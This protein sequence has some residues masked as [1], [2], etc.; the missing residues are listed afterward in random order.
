M[1]DGKPPEAIWQPIEDLPPDAERRGSARHRERAQRWMH[2]FQD[3]NGRM[4]RLLT[5]CVFARNGECPPIIAPERRDEYI[6][7]LERADRPDRAA[8]ST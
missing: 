1:A 7:N 5:A 8:D 2:P 6:R 3:G 4:A